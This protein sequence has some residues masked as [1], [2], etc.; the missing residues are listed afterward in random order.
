MLVLI[1]KQGRPAMTVQADPQAINKVPRE[2][3]EGPQF[4]RLHSYRVALPRGR[5]GFGRSR[6]HSFHFSRP[7]ALADSEKCKNPSLQSDHSHFVDTQ[8]ADLQ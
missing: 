4:L 3:S 2:G 7:S 6:N 5:G 1:Q 8:R